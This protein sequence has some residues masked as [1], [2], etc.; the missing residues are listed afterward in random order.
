MVFSWKDEVFQ[1]EHI[2]YDLYYYWQQRVH[3]NF[4][5]QH[6][7]TLDEINDEMRLVK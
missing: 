6:R 3:Y 5:T 1:K 4:E 7:N 2:T